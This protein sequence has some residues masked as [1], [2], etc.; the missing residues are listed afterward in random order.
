MP[1]FSCSYSWSLTDTWPLVLNVHLI[2]G[3]I[4]FFSLWKALTLLWVLTDTEWQ[5]RVNYHNETIM[6]STT[7]A[8]KGEVISS[9]FIGIK[10]GGNNPTKKKREKIWPIHM[11]TLLYHLIICFQAFL[12]AWKPL[13]MSLVVVWWGWRDKC[14][15]GSRHKWI[16]NNNKCYFSENKG[17]EQAKNPLWIKGFD[18]NTQKNMRCL[19]RSHWKEETLTWCQCDNEQIGQRW[20][21]KRMRETE[22]E[23]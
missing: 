3:L 10:F 4:L 23:I 15:V 12:L 11:R 5:S 13:N 21:E 20:G 1:S 22:R 9:S 14:R 6:A 19:T 8:F 2:T 7:K 18:W 17:A 16:K